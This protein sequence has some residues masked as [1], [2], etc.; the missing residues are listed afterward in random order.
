MT[1][2]SAN[3]VSRSG[4]SA[5]DLLAAAKK[6]EKQ[7]NSLVWAFASFKDV[8]SNVARPSYPSERIHF[9]QGPVEA[10]IPNVNP[11]RIALLRLDTDWYESTLHELTNLYPKLAVGGILMIDDYGDWQGCK[12]AVDEYFCKQQVFLNRIDATG[13]LLVKSL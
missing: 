3:D 12:K 8:Q 6:Y 9:V 2:P 11:E 5:G 13:R 7:E 1:D 4:V 10:N